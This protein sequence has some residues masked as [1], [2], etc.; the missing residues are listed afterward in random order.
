MLP[1]RRCAHLERR[2]ALVRAQGAQSPNL[3]DCVSTRSGFGLR[4]RRRWRDMSVRA[5]KASA[6]SLLQRRRRC[7][8]VP[9]WSAGAREVLWRRAQGRHCRLRREQRSGRQA[10][11][12]EGDARPRQ[13]AGALGRLPRRLGGTRCSQPRRHPAC[14]HS[15]VMGLP[16]PCCRARRLNTAGWR[17]QEGRLCTFMFKANNT[18]TC[19][20]SELAFFFL[21]PFAVLREVMQTPCFAPARSSS[22]HNVAQNS[23]AHASRASYAF[24]AAHQ[25]R[26]TGPR[27]LRPGSPGNMGAFKLVPINDV[28]QSC[29]PEGG[30]KLWEAAPF[31]LGRSAGPADGFAFPMNLSQLSSRH[32]TLRMAGEVRRQPGTAYGWGSALLSPHLL[33]RGRGTRRAERCHA[34]RTHACPGAMRIPLARGPLRQAEL[35]RLRASAPRGW[36]LKAPRSCRSRSGV[37]LTTAAATRRASR[38]SG[39]SWTHPPMAHL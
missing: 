22:F 9:V 36:R 23:T 6:A 5:L 26:S 12:D 2:V 33:A 32:C 29:V 35:A 10:A 19:R 15:P 21:R 37:P 18:E 13:H 24:S 39:P 25:E 8:D 28:A 7:G 34:Q 38:V 4:Q 31:L 1:G 11:E 14:R 16:T 20:C 27:P 3:G 30:I 17:R